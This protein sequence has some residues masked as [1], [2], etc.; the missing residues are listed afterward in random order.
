MRSLNGPSGGG[1]ERGGRM[2][3]YLGLIRRLA[4]AFGKVG[5]DYAFT[6]ALATSFY[7]LPRTTTDVDLFIHVTNRTAKSKLV[8][9]LERVAL[10]VDAGKVDRAFS[11]GYSIATFADRKTAYSVDVIFS[12]R[13]LPKR[14]GTIG[15]VQTFFHAPEDLI[16]AKLRIIKAKLSEERVLKDKEDVRAILKFT[17]V[18]IDAVRKK[19]K[20]ETTLVILEALMADEND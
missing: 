20:R 3:D 18:N 1:A 14:A 10:R 15:A 9:A 7:G 17:D 5:L 13:K 4:E 2:E 19:A 11:S 16:S 8:S 12:D 6:G